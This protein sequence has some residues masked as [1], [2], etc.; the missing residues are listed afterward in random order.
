MDVEKFLA[1]DKQSTISIA[2]V[3]DCI[4]DA[5]YSV[6]VDR[7]SPEF[8]IQVLHSL[9]DSPHISPGGAACVAHQASHFNVNC[10]L[11]GCLDEASEQQLSKYKFSVRSGRLVDGHIPIKRRLYDGNHALTRWDI[12][13]PNYGAS[14]IVE[15]RAEVVEKFEEYL[16]FNKVDVVILTCYGKGL[17]TPENCQKFIGICREYN[18]PTV[19]DPKDGPVEKWCGCTV[20]KPNE[21]EA[22]KLSGTNTNQAAV[23]RD[24]LDCRDVVITHGGK[25]ADGIYDFNKPFSCEAKKNLEVMSVIGAG[26]VFSMALS[27]CL[28]RGFEIP[29]AVQLAYCAGAVY[30]TNKYNKPITPYELHKFIDP[31]GAKIL[32]ESKLPVSGKIVFSNGVYDICHSGHLQTLEFAKNKGDYLVVGVNSDASVRRLK[33]KTRPILSLEQRMRMLAS[34]QMVDFVVPFDEDTPYELIQKLGK[35]NV[36]V[37]GGD[38]SVDTIIGADLVDEVYTC[39][40]VPDISTTRL[41]EKCTHL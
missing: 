32:T 29:E 27:M 22:E 16:S 11:F 25:C 14:N 39:P 10:V 18:I 9:S 2:V 40:L 30:V 26:D 1:L 8:P 38:Y 4:L 34:L 20:F 19:V 33:G 37:K 36:L 17:F 12:E 28:A 5:Y 15:A 31:I 21:K 6:R 24:I 3:G 35:I 13:A 7:I 41:I 23:L